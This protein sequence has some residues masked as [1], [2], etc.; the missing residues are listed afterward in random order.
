MGVAQQKFYPQEVPIRTMPY[1]IIVVPVTLFR[2]NTLRGTA[3]IHFRFRTLR[4]TNLQILTPKRYDEQPRHFH[5]EVPPPQVISEGLITGL[6]W[7][8]ASL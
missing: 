4:G 8:L 7:Y 2:L 6:L 1:K 5:M 3:I